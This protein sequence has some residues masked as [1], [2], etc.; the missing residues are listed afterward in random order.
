MKCQILFPGKKIEIIFQNV[1]S[2][3]MLPRLLCYSENHYENAPMQIYRKFHLQ[4]LKI[5]K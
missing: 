2:C 3:K 1:V 5:F 4:N